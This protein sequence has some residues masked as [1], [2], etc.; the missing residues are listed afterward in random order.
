M[1]LAMNYILPRKDDYTTIV[2]NF[3][4]LAGRIICEHLVA[5]K[6]NNPKKMNWH[7]KVC[8]I[9]VSCIMHEFKLNVMI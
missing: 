8:F 5:F 2:S 9:E 7:D 4:I 3:A 6:D 1:T